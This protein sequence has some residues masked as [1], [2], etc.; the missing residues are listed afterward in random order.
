[1]KPHS[2]LVVLEVTSEAGP[3]QAE[4]L[5]LLQAIKA[6]AKKNG[7]IEIL[8]QNVLL[9][10]LQNGLQLASELM[11]QAG[12]FGFRYRALFFE[13]EPPWIRSAPVTNTGGI[14]P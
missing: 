12:Q 8:A 10:P 13:E 6:A 5:A 11:A 4:W 7:Q 9:I 2:V 3:K 1:M 14:Y